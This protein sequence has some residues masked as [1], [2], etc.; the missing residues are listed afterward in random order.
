MVCS[1]TQNQ[2]QR[3]AAFENLNHLRVTDKTANSPTD[4]TLSTIQTVRSAEAIPDHT[5]KTSSNTNK[6]RSHLWT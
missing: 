3:Y 1:T 4:Q 6:P 5:I 2:K